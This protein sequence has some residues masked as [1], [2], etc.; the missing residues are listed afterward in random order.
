MKRSK[1]YF[2]YILL[3]LSFCL[4]IFLNR[5]F[6]YNNL[7][8][9]ITRILW[10]IVRLFLTFDQEVVWTF[11]IIIVITL[12]LIMIPSQQE[13]YVQSGSSNASQINDRAAFWQLQFR[14]ADNDT[15]N[16][17]SLQQ[18]LEGLHRSVHELVGGDEGK[19]IILPIP[20]T[21][22]WQLITVKLKNLFDRIPTKRK[23]YRDSELEST[24]NQI[25]ESMETLMEIQNDQSSSNSKNC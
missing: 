11:L 14:S 25:L 23:K 2:P 24:I 7:V 5:S 8:D 15:V 18:N 16:R 17:L 10:L 13:N 22:T 20:K 21:T 1:R 12:G 9:P 6:F 19:E 3:L 4:L